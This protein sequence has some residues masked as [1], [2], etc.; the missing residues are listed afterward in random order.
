MRSGCPPL[1]GPAGLP[2]GV[3]TAVARPAAHAVGT[4]PRAR[5]HDRLVGG[6]SLVEQVDEAGHGHALLGGD[7]VVS[8]SATVRSMPLPVVA[9]G[10]AVGGRRHDA[11]RRRRRGPAP[12]RPSPRRSGRRRP[13]AGRARRRTPRGPARGRGGRG[14]TSG[15]TGRCA[16][17]ST[18]SPWVPSTSS[19][20][21]SPSR[22]RTARS[23]DGATIV[24]RTPSSASTASTRSLTAVSGIHMP[25]GS[26][27]EAVAEVG[28]PP[29]HLGA[30]VVVVAER[31]D[32]VAVALGDAAPRPGG[33]PR[34][35]ARRP[36]GGARRATTGASGPCSRRAGRA[37]RSR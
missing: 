21:L 18:G 23:C 1:L 34:P 12:S 31:E 30:Q 15:R 33:P 27:A 36:R 22:G 35:P 17:V 9:E 14:G 4:G 20:P 13:G 29:P 19:H 26:A 5:P 16:K 7:V 6:G 25:S 11:R 37:G 8:A 32:R 2:A 10:L 24:N 3:A 28:D